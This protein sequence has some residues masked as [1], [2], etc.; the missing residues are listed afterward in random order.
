LQQA[1]GVSPGRV[2]Q[3]DRA[4]DSVASDRASAVGRVTSGS[5]GQR[6]AAAV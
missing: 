2:P 1:P 3:F 5:E 6:F 4:R